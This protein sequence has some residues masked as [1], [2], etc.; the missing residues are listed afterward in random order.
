[1]SITSQFMSIQGREVVSTQEDCG[2]WHE[3]EYYP[4]GEIVMIR[5]QICSSCFEAAG[6]Y[7]DRLSIDKRA[8]LTLSLPSAEGDRGQDGSD[9]T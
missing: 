6:V 7:L 8:Q 1:M 5:L 9:Q 3:T 4:D 2:C